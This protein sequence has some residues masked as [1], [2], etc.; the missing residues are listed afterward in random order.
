MR[1]IEDPANDYAVAKML[2]TEL[3]PFI[4]LIRVADRMEL[5]ED[6]EISE[7][8]RAYVRLVYELENLY[9]KN[10]KLAEIKPEP[11]W[12][13]FD[14]LRSLTLKI[15]EYLDNP[16]NDMGQAHIARLDKLC[17][18]SGVETP[19]LLPEQEKLAGQAAEAVK[20]YLQILDEA[21]L[22][23]N[24]KIEESWYIPEYK[25]G[26]ESDGTILINDVL[27]LKKT[28]IG[29]TIDQLLE[30]AFKNQNKPFD[31]K[32]QQT[33]RNLSTLLSSAGFT[34]TLRRLF[35]PVVSKRRGVLFRATVSSAQASKEKID[36]TKLDLILMAL[37]ADHTFS[38]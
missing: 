23:I 17:I 38:A 12:K 27:R 31:P 5:P 1:A 18:I 11:I 19:E 8:N 36:T 30:Q 9:S 16:E 3:I 21:K 29:S 28:H 26:Y 25:L 13:R 22:G 10:P 33:A 6:Y 20:K 32:L 37:D 4:A 35:F 24:A 15:N 14:V 34:P 2:S 7:L